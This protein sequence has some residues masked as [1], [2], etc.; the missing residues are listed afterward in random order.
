MTK[1]INIVKSFTADETGAVASEYAVLLVLIAAAL[2]TAVL[3]LSGAITGAMD[4]VRDVILTCG[5][6]GC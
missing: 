5:G 2:V 3:L 1:F 6:G 4:R